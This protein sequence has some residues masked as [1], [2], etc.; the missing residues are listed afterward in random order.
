M[1]IPSFAAIPLN[2][3]RFDLALL[4]FDLALLRFELVV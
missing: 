4:R 3:P 2:A 1:A